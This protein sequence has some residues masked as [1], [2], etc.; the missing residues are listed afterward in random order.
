MSDPIHDLY[1]QA[2][3]EA[4]AFLTPGPAKGCKMCDGCQYEWT[5]ALRVL[6]EVLEPKGFF[7]DSDGKWQQMQYTPGPAAVE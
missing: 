7:C 5:E 6:R 2:V 4:I 3:K 1:V